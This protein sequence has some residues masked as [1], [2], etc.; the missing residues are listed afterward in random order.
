MLPEISLNILDIVQN[1]IS[2]EATH[3]EIRVE[4]DSRRHLLTVTVKDNGRGMSEDALRAVTDPFFTTRTT[5]T[6]GLGIPFF[7]QAAECTGGTFSIVSAC[8]AGTA[9][10]AQ[11]H[12]DHIDCMP[13]GDVNATIYMLVT[14]NESVDFSYTYRVD[15]TSFCLDTGEMRQILGDVPFHQA[16]VSEFIRNYLEENETEVNKKAGITGR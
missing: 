12:T 2:A 9:V 7:K 13:L 6:V 5:R 3:I 15:E 1:S 8:G 14:M 4:S 16:E 11:F 10:T